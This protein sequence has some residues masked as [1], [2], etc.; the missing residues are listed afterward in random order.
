L[1]AD[2][3]KA[4]GRRKELEQVIAQRCGVSEEAVLLSSMP[5]VSYFTTVALAC[6]VGR[7]ERFPR[8]RS[9]V[10]SGDRRLF[11]VAVHGRKE[12]TR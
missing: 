11:I 10:W 9:L 7:V 8:A 2:L 1:L 12:A 4:Q 6:R 5:G 3:E